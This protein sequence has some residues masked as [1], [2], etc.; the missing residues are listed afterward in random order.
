MEEINLRILKLY[1]ITVTF[2]RGQGT[3]IKVSHFPTWKEGSEW[4]LLKSGTGW[5]GMG[6]DSPGY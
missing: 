1:N 3:R 4:E 5:D 2:I 6:R